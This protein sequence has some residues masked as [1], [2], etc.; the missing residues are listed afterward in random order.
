MKNKGNSVYDIGVLV[1]KENLQIF[2]DHFTVLYNHSVDTLTYPDLLK[3]AVVVLGHKSGSKDDINNYRPISNLPVVSKIFEKLTLTRLLS[4][5]NKYSILSNSQFGFRKGKN[6]TQAA[7]KLTTTIVNAYHDKLYVSCFFLDL[8]KAFDTIDHEILLRKMSHQG[9]REQINHYLRSYLTGREQYVQV[10]DYKSQCLNITKGVPQGS[11]L[12]PLLFNLYINDIADCVDEE[13]VLFADD[14][15]FIITAPSL[16]RMYEKIRKLFIDLNRYLVTNKLVPNL[17]KSKLMFFNSRPKVDLEA[18]V[19]GAETIEWVE[20]FK[21]LGLIL[22]AKMSYS[23][24]INKICTKISQHIGIFSHL[25][26]VVPREVLVLLYHAFIL[27]HL[28]LHIEL[29]GAAPE[30]HISKLR[31]KQNNLLRAILNVEVVNGVPQQRTIDMYNNLGLLT[32][33]NLFKLYL[34]KFLS[35]LLK[36]DLPIFYDLLLRPLLPNHRYGTR[37]GRFRHPLIVC[38]VKRR[39]ELTTLC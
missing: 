24:H 15:A 4:F 5:V 23:N 35:L 2:S 7:M 31:V 19:F 26:K 8:R 13:V 37:T 22:N 3:K 29:W 10:G 14:A 27:P 11:I 33:N 6:I 38:E 34:I 28:T 36:G 18:L 1:L 32:L 9:F 21:Y 30:W 12:G 16:Q 25:S 20:E 17:G 39:A